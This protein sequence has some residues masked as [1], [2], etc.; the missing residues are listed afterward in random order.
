MASQRPLLAVTPLEDRPLGCRIEGV[1]LTS[2]DDDQ[3]ATIARAFAKYQLVVLSNVEGLLPGNELSFY[4]RLE[5]LWGKSSREVAA[6]QQPQLPP[7]TTEATTHA[8]ASASDSYGSSSS[9]SSSSTRHRSII[10]L[11][12]AHPGGVAEISLLGNG[13]VKDHFGLTGCLEPTPWWE[14][15]SMQWH[16][17]GSFDGK[18]VNICTL[19]SC[20][21]APSEDDGGVEHCIRYQAAGSNATAVRDTELYVHAGATC[22]AST[23]LAYELCSATEKQQIERLQVRY[24]SKPSGFG[25]VRTGLYPQMSDCGTRVVN[26][27]PKSDGSVAWRNIDSKAHSWSKP[28]LQHPQQQGSA[29]GEEQ[30]DVIT[31]AQ[32][33]GIPGGRLEEHGHDGGVTSCE[34]WEGENVEEGFTQPLVLMHPTTRRRSVFVHTVNMMR[35]E[36]MET[37]EWL[38]WEASQALVCKLFQRVVRPDRSVVHNWRP[39]D[40]VFWDNRCTLHSVTPSDFFVNVGARRLMHRISLASTYR[41]RELATSSKEPCEGNAA[42]S[43]ATKHSKL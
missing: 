4:R 14:K 33:A 3:F 37:G 26:P 28:G 36:D 17:D 21:H 32:R 40:V 16:V 11:R 9:S 12:G 43:R 35:L 29:R 41:P 10:N 30:L 25:R 23:Y 7:P 19:M 13:E 1:C 8:A 42:V 22:F 6:R 24:W 34:P 39:N 27:P 2:I 20:F 15:A 31:L 38:S 5:T 18:D